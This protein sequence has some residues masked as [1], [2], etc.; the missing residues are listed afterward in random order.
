MGIRILYLAMGTKEIFQE[1]LQLLNIF[2]SNIHAL[3]LFTEIFILWIIAG[4]VAWWTLL[5]AI[6]KK[7]IKLKKLFKYMYICISD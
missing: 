2:F 5:N 1:F 4:G 3:I 7:Q 6:E